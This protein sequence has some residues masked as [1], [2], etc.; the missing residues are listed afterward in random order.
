MPVESIRC[1][2]AVDLSEELETAAEDVLGDLRGRT[3]GVRWVRPEQ[4]HVTLQFYGEQPP[5][6]VEDLTAALL[7]ATR[8][9]RP[10]E[11]VLRGAGTFP[12][13]GTPRVVWLGLDDVDG[14]LAKLHR[15]VTQASRELGFRPER[16]PFRPHLTLGRVRREARPAGL[17]E[18]LAPYAQRTFGSCTIGEL[19]LYRSE[20]RPEGARY[21]VIAGANLEGGNDR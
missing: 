8:P 12:P 11:V 1:F 18:A 19:K 15:A 20:L 13:R 14:G 10:A 2:A 5:D 17:V 7:E 3:A 6:V 4:L 21:S 9:L 16:R